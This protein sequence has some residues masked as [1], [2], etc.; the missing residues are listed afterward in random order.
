[1]INKLFLLILLLTVL[2]TITSQE[3]DISISYYNEDRD[4]S[5]LV[6]LNSS[7][8]EADI[9]I[10]NYIEKNLRNIP[11]KIIYVK[12][13]DDIHNGDFSASKYYLDNELLEIPR[14]AFYFDIN[15][16][17]KPKINAFNN[18]NLPDLE[19]TKEIFKNLN[20]VEEATIEL[21]LYLTS[22]LK[23]PGI[24]RDY[25]K[26]GVSLILFRGDIDVVKVL[27]ALSFET[28][29]K[30]K[31]NLYFLL[32]LFGKTYFLTDKIILVTMSLFLLLVIILICLYSKRIKFHIKHNKK[33]IITLPLKIVAVFIFYYIST[34]II[35]YIQTKSG[36]NR[37]IYSFPISIFIIKNLVL[38]F[39]YGICFHIIKD[40]SFSKSPHF[41]SFVSFF[42]SIATCAYLSLIY[43]PLGL[44]QIWPILMTIFFIIA[45]K[46]PTKRLF[47][48][49]SPLILIITFIKYLND[50][51]REFIHLFITSRYRGNILLTLIAS[52]Y[53][54]LQDSYH[55]L[56]TRR[57]NKIIYQRD[58][59]LSILLLTVTITYTAIILELQ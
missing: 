1:M 27:E 26:W 25:Q 33:Y 49:L 47:W 51:Q 58:I 8:I 17:L 31:Q 14:I 37:F 29:P 42:I 48:T 54:F 20:I 7:N 38:Y 23:N 41:Y 19:I 46:R 50:D 9:K 57:Q 4:E 45:K 36:N 3:A 43:L 44:Y 39:I 11:F 56:V 28:K 32:P 10:T 40:T 2:P 21:P 22:V 16:N 15:H 6:L 18:R 12:L 24:L 34:L 30:I 52:P 35:E 55:R 53:L 13:E 5:I 59:I